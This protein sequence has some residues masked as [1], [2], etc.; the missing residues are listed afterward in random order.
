M[1]QWANVLEAL[2]RWLAKR[3]PHT[4]RRIGRW[5]G[6]L[7][8]HTARRR[9]RVALRN[10]ELCFPEE[11]PA[12]RHRLAH[13]HFIALAQSVVDRG[14]LWFGTPEQIRDLMASTAIFAWA[15]R[16]MLNLGE[17]VWPE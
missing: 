16:L 14:V 9:R 7:A 2:L 4:R 17:H 12:A 15:N 1:I 6:N 11:S 8:W 5:L 3:S 10:I 13:R